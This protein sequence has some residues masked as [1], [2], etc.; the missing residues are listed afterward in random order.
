MRIYNVVVKPLWTL[1]KGLFKNRSFVSHWRQTVCRRMCAPVVVKASDV[2]RD[3]PP[4]EF[5]TAVLL[6]AGPFTLQALKKRSTTALTLLC[7]AG[8]VESA[9][10]AR[11]AR[12]SGYNSRTI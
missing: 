9:R 11:S 7:Q 4:G 5:V 8:A 2:V 10:S 3:V 6:L 1:T 12:M